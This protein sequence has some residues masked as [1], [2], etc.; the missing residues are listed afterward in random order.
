MKIFQVDAFA[1]KP[2]EGNPAGVCVLEEPAEEAWMQAFANEMNLAETAYTWPEGDGWR[3]RWFTPVA[4]V[5]LCG[6]A[7]LA[8]AHTLYETGSVENASVI[9]FQTR[10]GE[11][12]VTPAQR[13]LCLNFPAEP[14]AA[15]P[16]PE[17]L[18][19]AV[20]RGIEAAPVWTGANRMDLFIQ[21][22]SESV[23]R[24]L[25]PALSQIADVDVRGV[26]VTA[27]ADS[28]QPY[29][30]VSRFFAPRYGVPEDPVTGSAHCAIAPFWSE[31]L[32]MSRLR[33]Y[34]AS[35]RGGLVGMNHLGDRVELTGTAVTIFQALLNSRASRV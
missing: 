29:D 32:G 27:P 31:R 35:P 15:Q 13:G 4:E 14:P 7:T 28:G 2:F 6:H 5:D 3:L 30:V 17:G 33:G 11:L 20:F 12:K 25:R 1:S 21:A 19:E 24:A 10:S 34:Q 18:T 26:I 8:A 22:E 16:L 9:R 23:V